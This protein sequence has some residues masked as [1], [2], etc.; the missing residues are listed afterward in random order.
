MVSKSAC[1]WLAAVV[2]AG[3]LFPMQ[4]RADYVVVSGGHS[5]TVTQNQNDGT[6]ESIAVYPPDS[7]P[8]IG[9]EGAGP[10]PGEPQTAPD[11][12]T[13]IRLITHEDTRFFH[14]NIKTL[15]LIPSVIAAQRYGSRNI[16][17]TH[18]VSIARR[19]QPRND[20]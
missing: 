11:G 7:A 17:P 18:R 1:K 12:K 10:G 4:A 3:L 16:K 2:L 19:Y 8:Y 20:R 14:C 15:N 6:S 13:P 9:S 5:Y